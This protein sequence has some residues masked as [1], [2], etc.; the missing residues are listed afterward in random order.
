MPVSHRAA[1]PDDLNALLTR[2][3]DKNPD[4]NGDRVFSAALAQFLMANMPWDASERSRVYRSAARI[5][6]DELFRDRV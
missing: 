2:F 1:I 6:L 5:Y 3:L 4:W